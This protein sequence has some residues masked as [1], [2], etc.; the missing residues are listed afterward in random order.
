MFILTLT[1][2][3]NNLRKI[4][5]NDLL[6]SSNAVSSASLQPLIREVCGGG[7]GGQNLLS[8][9]M[10]RV[11]RNAPKRGRELTRHDSGLRRNRLM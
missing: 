4:P 5:Y 2:S 9:S 7:G 11:Q 8:P 3:A 1:L 6:G 10:G